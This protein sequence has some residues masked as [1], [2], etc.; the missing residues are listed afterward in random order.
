MDSIENTLKI[1]QQFDPNYSNGRKTDEDKIC[2]YL[3]LYEYQIV[4]MQHE[5]ELL[6]EDKIIVEKLL[7]NQTR[8][9]AKNRNLA[10]EKTL[11]Q[12]YNA[13]NQEMEL[14]QIQLSKIN[15][16]LNDTIAEKCKQE[17]LIQKETASA[18]SAE[19][20]SNDNG[21]LF[22][23]SLVPVGFSATSDEVKLIGST[24][25]SVGESKISTVMS[26]NWKLSSPITV[27][28]QQQ[29]QQQF[30]SI[31]NIAN[32]QTNSPAN[33]SRVDKQQPNSANISSMYVESRGGFEQ[34]KQPSIDRIKSQQLNS[35][36]DPNMSRSSDSLYTMANNQLNPNGY[37]IINLSSSNRIGGNG[38]FNPTTKKTAL[39]DLN[40]DA[41]SVNFQPLNFISKPKP[42]QPAQKLVTTNFRREIIAEKKRASIGKYPNNTSSINISSNSGNVNT[43]YR[44]NK[45]NLKNS[46]K[47]FVSNLSMRASI[48]DPITFS[49]FSSHHR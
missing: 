29:Q 47:Y 31:D 49:Q 15:Q 43:F 32:H 3:K 36:L 14:L 2:N 16:L 17:I 24:P 4:E 35:K 10:N 33:L 38:A 26:A 9:F 21:S 5:Y 30:G 19:T 25:N 34:L 27:G 46:F 8:I 18:N 39:L 40:D 7:D 22:R 6:L 12:Q 42:V 20:K 41:S 11:V 13:L 28:K 48:L 37:E 23:A 45:L 44:K 1:A